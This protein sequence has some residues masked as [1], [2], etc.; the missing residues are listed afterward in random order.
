MFP[1][2]FWKILQKKQTYK[3]LLRIGLQETCSILWLR[4]RKV[5]ISPPF[6]I[7]LLPGLFL[8]LLCFYNISPKINIQPQ[9]IRNKHY[10]YMG[11]SAH[12]MHPTHLKLFGFLK[13]RGSN[14][15]QILHQVQGPDTAQHVHLLWLLIPWWQ[16]E[17]HKCH[18]PQ[19]MYRK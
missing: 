15:S 18:L 5:R 4:L 17:L 2:V 16:Q 7:H 1:I 10:L 12:Q 11:T 14:R 9:E 8:W 19:G 3:C 13:K 6:S